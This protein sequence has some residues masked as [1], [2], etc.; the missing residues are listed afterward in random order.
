[1]SVLLKAGHLSNEE[2]TDVFYNAETDEIIKLSSKRVHTK[3]THGTG[4]TFSSAITA[5]L[6]HD[7]PLNESIR[8]AKEY[9]NQTIVT[10]AAYEI[11]K[12]HGPVH[13]FFNFWE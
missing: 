7:K 12:G 3:N 4:C 6:A 11:G 2:L 13:H 1:V 8:L 10:G 5:F 9:I